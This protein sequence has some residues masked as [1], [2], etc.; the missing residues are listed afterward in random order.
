[1][2]I[3]NEEDFSK[4]QWRMSFYEGNKGEYADVYKIGNLAI[5]MFY[6]PQYMSK[7]NIDRFDAL[8]KVETNRFVMP[9]DIICV[10][11]LII[12]YTMP[13]I[14]DKKH[15]LYNVDMTLLVKELKLIKKDVYNFTDKRIAIR[16]CH[17]ANIIFNGHLYVID[18]DDYMPISVYP[19]FFCE[20]PLPDKGYN[21]HNINLYQINM[22]V[23]N[24]LKNNISDNFCSSEKMR[25]DSYL[26]NGLKKLGG[27]YY[28]FIGDFLE[29]DIDGSETLG[30][31]S[32]RKI[33]QTERVVYFL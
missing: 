32:K 33:K 27:Q 18:T 23:I 24:F 15:P 31:Y 21:L 6:N 5:K 25:I 2:N 17:G 13:Y 20:L 28:S 16:D 3:I 30:D 1:M 4:M 11:N 12:G 22:G 29:K 26:H 7:Q 19:N 9:S 8:N 10:D 14:D